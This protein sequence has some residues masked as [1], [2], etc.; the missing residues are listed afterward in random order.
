M[1]MDRDARVTIIA[2][3]PELNGT[4]CTVLSFD[5]AQGLY[6]VLLEREHELEHGHG[7]EHESERRMRLRP[8][9]LT[10]HA[11]PLEEARAAVAEA[12]ASGALCGVLARFD[13]GWQ[14]APQAPLALQQAAAATPAG[15]TPAESAEERGLRRREEGAALHALLCEEATHLAAAALPE[16]LLPEGLLDLGTLGGDM[17]AA[18]GGAPGGRLTLALTLS[19]T[20]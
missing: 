6:D 11:S 5:A 17:P 14:A 15:G 20:L 13:A 1:S 18:E 9:N 3:S 19:L 12:K 4:R 10:P 7:H 8:A 16:G 2:V